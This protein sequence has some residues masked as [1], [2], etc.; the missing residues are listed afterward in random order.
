MS[1]DAERDLDAWQV[2]AIEQGLADANAGRVVAHE[3][4]IAWVNSWGRPDE[5]PM[6]ESFWDPRESSDTD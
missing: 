2:Q 5:L 6:P 4:V 3:R 1:Q